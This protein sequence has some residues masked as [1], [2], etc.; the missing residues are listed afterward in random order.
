MEQETPQYPQVTPEQI[1]LWVANAV[2]QAYLQCLELKMLDV[3]DNASDGAIVDS[4]SAD[5]THAMIH[6][7]LGQQQA[8]I[9]SGDYLGLLNS[10]G[11][12]MET[13]DA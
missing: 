2:T 6:E 12:V 13:A 11:M 1:Q 5:L 4:S 10:Y 8:L 7:N 3:R 9:T